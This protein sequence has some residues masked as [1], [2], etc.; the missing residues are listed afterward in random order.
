MARDFA[1]REVN[2]NFS[3]GQAAQR[4]FAD[5][6]VSLHLAIHHLAISSRVVY[7]RRNTSLSF[8]CRSRR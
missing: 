3:Q 2:H 6:L 8:I 7:H 4:S 1:D 5:A